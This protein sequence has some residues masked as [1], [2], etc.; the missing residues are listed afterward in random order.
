MYD[1]N[2]IRGTYEEHLSFSGV[3][4][5][6]KVPDRKDEITSPNENEFV[7]TRRQEKE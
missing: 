6:L 3:W 4:W 5:R 2:I 7:N 1:K